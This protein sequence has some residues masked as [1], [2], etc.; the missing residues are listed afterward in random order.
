MKGKPYTPS[1][2]TDGDIFF[3]RW[4]DKCAAG[5]KCPIIG[6][7]LSGGATE[8]REFDD[9]RV[10]CMSF[11]GMAAGENMFLVEIQP[12][13]WLAPWRGDPGRT[14][15]FTS[16]KRFKSARAARAALARH[17]ALGR[18]IPPMARVVE[19]TDGL[20]QC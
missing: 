1:N 17:R 8:W 14:L 13:C 12:G 6:R 18:I 5:K 9:G 16:A 15:V 11:R 3:S 10:V 20:G 4:C 2:G 7:A 19:V